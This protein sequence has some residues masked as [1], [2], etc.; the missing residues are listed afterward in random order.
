MVEE[1][2][3]Y[4]K[5]NCRDYPY[6]IDH[7]SGELETCLIYGPRNSSDEWKVLVELAAKYVTGN[8]TKDRGNHPVPKISLTGSR[9]IISLLIVRWM[10][11]Y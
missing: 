11:S 1:Y 7:L 6:S 10:K 8:N 3:T 2:Y 4:C 9:R 5:V